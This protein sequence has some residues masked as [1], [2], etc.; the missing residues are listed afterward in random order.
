MGQTK[1]LYKNSWTCVNV[2]DKTIH[3]YY[4]TNTSVIHLS[5]VCNTTPLAQT[6][7]ICNTHTHTQQ[8][9]QPSTEY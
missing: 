4:I 7:L 6:N 9:H 2:S 1:T 5:V 8:Q 3:V